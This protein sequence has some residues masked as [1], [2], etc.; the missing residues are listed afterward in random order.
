MLRTTD[1]ARK[2]YKQI[3]FHLRELR[4]RMASGPGEHLLHAHPSLI[5]H[6]KLLFNLIVAHGFVSDAFGRGIKVPLV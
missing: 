2:K 1:S 5:I 6:L 3:D 4:L